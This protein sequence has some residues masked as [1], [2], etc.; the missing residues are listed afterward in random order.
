MTVSAYAGKLWCIK[1]NGDQPAVRGDERRGV[2]KREVEYHEVTVTFIV[3]KREAARAT[4]VR[5]TSDIRS[6][7][8][9]ILAAAI[10]GNA[11]NCLDAELVEVTID[12]DKVMG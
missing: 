2:V 5:K 12:A 11:T 4:G 6:R 3:S 10:T 1:F 7:L 8:A 9:T